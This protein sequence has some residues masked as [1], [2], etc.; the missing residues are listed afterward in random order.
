MVSN[1]YVA[2]RYADAE[3][4]RVDDV[5]AFLCREDAEKAAALVNDGHG[6]PPSVGVLACYHT[7]AA[8]ERAYR[9]ELRQKALGKLT[10]A[11]RKALGL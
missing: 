2:Y 5:A 4:R 6:N 9:D 10:P 11:E 1:V 3:G 7:F 8:F